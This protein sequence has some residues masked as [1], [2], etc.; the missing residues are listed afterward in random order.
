MSEREFNTNDLDEDMSLASQL[1]RRRRSRRSNE[2][3]R[4][5]IEDDLQSE[6]DGGFYEEETEVPDREDSF[7]AEAWDRAAEGSLRHTRQQ[8]KRRKMRITMLGISGSGKTAFLSGVYQ[9]MMMDNFHGLALLSAAT[10][11][12][13]FRQ[14]GQIADIALVNR[15][16]EFAL[17]TEETTVFPLTLEDGGSEIC[18][19]DFTDYRGGDVIDILNARGDVSASARALQ[20]QLISSDAILIFADAQLL[21]QSN[22]RVDWQ[23]ATGAAMINPLF[24]ALVKAMDYRPLTV[25][26]VLTKTDD[27]SIPYDLK[28]NRFAKLTE[29]A[30]QAFD[31]VYQIALSHIDD[32]WNF[33]VV[34]VSA[35]GEGN[36]ETV[37]RTVNGQEVR[38]S[39]VK[40]GCS[41]E[42][43][44][45]EVTMIYTIACILSQW[46][47]ADDQEK[48]ALTEKLIE[49]GRGNTLLGNLFSGFKKMPKPETKVAALL[50]SI[51]EKNRDIRVLNTH[52]G[53]LLDKTEARRIV[54]R[55]RDNLPEV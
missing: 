5:Q 10:S 43:Y 39:V 9:T 40:E 3:F 35:V 53:D 6:D 23:R 28:A 19:F 41:P 22:N 49:E 51:E 11:E 54:Q 48:E 26:L 4:E 24:R 37:V 14:I 20:R 44:N 27:E 13:A 18:D 47:R 36:S 55:R 12:Q 17:G 30:M 2:V 33:G 16:Y 52:I 32:G 8:S 1:G 25:L 34:P 21:C 7:E 38:Q 42:P 45:I 31:S 46:K 15:N 50:E 29:R